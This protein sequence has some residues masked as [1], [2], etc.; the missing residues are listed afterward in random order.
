MLEHVV[1]GLE[2]AL[3]VRKREQTQKL[4][5]QTLQRHVVIRSMCVAQAEGQQTDMSFPRLP[6]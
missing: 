2:V 3:R 6:R 4:V 5:D 1:L